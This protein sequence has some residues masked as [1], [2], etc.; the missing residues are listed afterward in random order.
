MDCTVSFERTA[1]TVVL[2]LIVVQVPV[3]YYSNAILVPLVLGLLEHLSVLTCAFA[4]S[5]V[6]NFLVYCSH[7]I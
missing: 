6:G 7:R 4:Y 3:V 2:T 5:E 1:R